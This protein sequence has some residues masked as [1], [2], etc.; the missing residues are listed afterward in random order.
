MEAITKPTQQLP[1]DKIARIVKNLV[2][3]TRGGR[4]VS[5]EDRVVA[6]RQLVES[7]LVWNAAYLL[8][9]ILNLNGKPYT[10]Q[11]HF[12]FEAV[13]NIRMPKRMVFKAARQVSKSTSIASRGVM[14]TN[15]IPNFKML[16]LTPLYE[17][18]RRFSANYVR[19]FID[20]SPVKSLWTGTSTENSVLQRTFKNNSKMIFSFAY[21]D[22]DRTRGI[23]SDCLSI[24]EI[25]DFDSSFIPIVAESMS[26]S[27]WKMLT[28]MG[29]P[30]T[31]DN[32]LEG[33]WQK[34]SMGEWCMPC[35]ACHHLN[36]AA[37]EYDLFKM[38]GPLP[39]KSELPLSES[40]PGTVCSKCRK[41]LSPR[42]GR[43]MHRRKELRIDYPGYHVPQPIMPIHYADTEAWRDI[44]GKREG[45]NNTSQAT[46]DNETMGESCDQGIKLVT[47]TD[48]KRAAT[49]PWHNDP[50]GRIRPTEALNHRRDYLEVVMG[51]DWGGGGDQEVSFTKVAVLGLKGTGQIDVIY[52]RMLLTP[53]QHFEE[54]REIM[55]IFNA[56]QCDFLAHDYNGAGTV[57]E[58]VMVQSG[59]AEDRVVP[60]VYH[61]IGKHNPVVFHKSEAKHSRDYWLL[62]KAIS[63]LMTASCIKLA[64]IQF[65]QYDFVDADNPGLLHD[66]LALVENKIET[67]RGRDMYSI[68]RNP[69]FQDDFAHAVNFGCAAIWH[70]HGW[71]N[72]AS[73]ANMQISAEQMQDISPHNPWGDD[74]EAM[75]GFLTR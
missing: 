56:F 73:L 34:S 11:D 3:E 26:H 67:A 12:P 44:L 48:L 35:P 54:A 37:K 68:Q 55:K 45:M 63:L 28:F 19:P 64:R 59:L 5:W 21:L 51:V 23:S 74:E 22:A 14:L 16:F 2:E 30:K 9:F 47:V 57:R 32:T 72:L 52:G 53:S 46:F 33:L 8:P 27:P 40:N 1:D 42:N 49:L 10:L 60:F 15:S 62:D 66:F 39:K 7:R 13:F 36:I 25:Q 18:I 65:F 71:P 58:S 61:P 6:F 4:P 69:Q 41:R 38:L 50:L 29:T 24:D 31:L 70:R 17:Q 43:W 75:G 20:Q